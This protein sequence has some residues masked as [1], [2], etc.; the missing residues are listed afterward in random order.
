L[1]ALERLAPLALDELAPP[2]SGKRWKFWDD[3]P[4]L[5][6]LDWELCE[7]GDA[8]LTVPGAGA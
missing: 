8:P 1:K 6:P 2:F 7:V 4:P 3:A 5:A